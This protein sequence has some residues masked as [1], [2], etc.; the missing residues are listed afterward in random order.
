MTKNRR[1]R[2]G[3]KP[4]YL[5]AAAIKIEDIKTCS[6]TDCKDKP[7]YIVYLTE[8][9]NSDCIDYRT[10]TPAHMF[11]CENHLKNIMTATH[12]GYRFD[13]FSLRGLPAKYHEVRA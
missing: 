13:R 1:E 6:A 10:I 12:G 5:G 7:V 11:S 9:H 8:G 4:K 3:Y 2:M